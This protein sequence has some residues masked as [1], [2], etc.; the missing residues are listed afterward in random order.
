MDSY[1]RFLAGLLHDLNSKKVRKLCYFLDNIVWFILIGSLNLCRTVCLAI[2]EA[3]EPKFDLKYAPQKIFHHGEI[4]AV[5]DQIVVTKM[6]CSFDVSRFPF[7]TQK[8]TMSF[9]SL[10]IDKK[11]FNLKG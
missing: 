4:R 3:V 8:C 10:T 6:L 11:L 1:E 7:D 5:D 9:R 2:E